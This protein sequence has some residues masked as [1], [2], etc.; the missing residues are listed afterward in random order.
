MRGCAR[1][2]FN[3]WR[4]SDRSGPPATCEMAGIRS[5]RVSRDAPVT[6]PT[7][8]RPDLRHAR[9]RLETNPPPATGRTC[10]TRA[11]GWKRIPAGHPPDLRHA[12]LRLETNPRRPPAGPA[13]RAPQVGNESPAG[14]R[15][16]LRHARLRL[17]TNPRRPPAG[18]AARAPQVGNESPPAT[19]RTCGTRASGWKRIP[20]G[21]RPDLRRARLRLET[22]PCRPPA[23]PAARAPQVGNE[24]PAGHRPD[25]RHARLRLETNPR[26]PPA[27]PA[28]RAPQV[29]NESPPATGRTCGTRASGW[30]RIP[31]GHRPDLRHARLRLETNPRRPPAGT[32]GTRASG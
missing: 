26:R 29:G 7:L 5:G 27:G 19:R 25:L 30:K 16:D 12:R 1:Q 32:C 21:H 9:L 6:R 4:G 14:H 17:E 3:N 10:G 22:N 28:A 11:S 20:A 23:G 2:K 13:A 15:P 18:P 8:H 24:S 31:A